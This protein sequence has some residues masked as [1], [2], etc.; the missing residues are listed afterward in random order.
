MKYSIKN[1]ALNI[2]DIS[3]DFLKQNIKKE[4]YIVNSSVI[5]NRKVRE[6]LI[7]NDYL[8]SPIK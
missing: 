6:Y 8:F 3:K 1:N 2:E 5:P 4:N 7:A